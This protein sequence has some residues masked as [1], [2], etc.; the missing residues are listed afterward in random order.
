MCFLT[1]GKKNPINGNGKFFF[2][3]KCLFFSQQLNAVQATSQRKFFFRSYFYFKD[4]VS[5]QE[6]L[7]YS[8]D[9]DSIIR[10]SN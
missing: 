1:V 8:S 10:V 6:V 9:V 7:K 2:A 4:D 3:K 5:S